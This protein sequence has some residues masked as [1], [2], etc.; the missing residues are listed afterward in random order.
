[1]ILSVLSVKVEKLNGYGY[2]EEIVMRRADRQLYKFKEGDFINLHLNEIEDMLLLVVHHKLFHL[3]GEVIV[4]L[5]VALRMFTRIL[6][7][8]KRVEDVQL[9]MPRIKWSDSDK[10]RSSIMVDLIDK[11]MLK[12]QILSNLERLVGARELEMDY[13]LM[14][15]T[16]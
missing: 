7:I 15:R 6:I 9:D 5:A 8:K 2:L 13:R 3:D 12:R 14:H 1:M 10:R 16:I 4:D 11:Q